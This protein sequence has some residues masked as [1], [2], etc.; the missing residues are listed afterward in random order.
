VPADHKWFTRLIVAQ[1]IIATLERLGLEYPKVDA[2][3]KKELAKARKALEKE[4]AR[5]LR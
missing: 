5:K 2:A 3:R 1:V 4:K